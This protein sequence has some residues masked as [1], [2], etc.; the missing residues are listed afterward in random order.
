MAN[1]TFDEF[2]HCMPHHMI[3]KLTDDQLRQFLR[4]YNY[5]PG[6]ILPTTRWLYECILDDFGI[7]ERMG[8]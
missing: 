5:N 7:A 2:D 6:P 1:R 4:S 8:R 3:R